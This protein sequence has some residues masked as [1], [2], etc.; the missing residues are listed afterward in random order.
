MRNDFVQFLRAAG[1]LFAAGATSQGATAQ[2]V[3]FELGAGLSTQLIDRGESLATFNNELALGVSRA[4]D[5]G[6]IY[7]ALYRISPLGDEGEAF[8]EEVDYTLGL[9]FEGDGI[10]FD[11]SVNLLT[12][13]GSAENSAIELAGEL[14]WDE[15]LQPVLFSFYD[16]ENDLFGAEASIIPLSVTSGEWT[17]DL[18]VRGG[19][20]ASEELDYSYGGVEGL[21]A[22]G[23]GDNAALE[24]FA[25]AEFADEDNFADD[26]QSGTVI[27]NRGEGYAA[28]V[29]LTW[30]ASP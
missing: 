18:L 29:R 12:F 24:L 2:D 23:F 9:V 5:F 4:T 21:L 27:T 19:F 10:A 6:A 8:E 3:E 11:T 22:R 13:P 1:W 26:I 17:A 25:R 15:P 20:V 28:G 30:V 16:L 14:S 7:G